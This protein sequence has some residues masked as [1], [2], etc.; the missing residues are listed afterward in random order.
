MLHVDRGVDIDSGVEQL[1]DILP[2]FGMPRA[3][4]VGMRQFIDEDQRGAACQRGIEV[5]FAEGGAT[6]LNGTPWQDVEPF[7]QGFGLCPAMRIHPAH[8]DV[9]TLITPLVGRFEHGVR[10][11][12]TSRG[13]KED[14]EFTA[15]LLGL[16]CLYTGEE[17]IGIRSLIVHRRV[18]LTVR[19]H[20]ALPEHHGTRAEGGQ[21]PVLLCTMRDAS[22]SWLAITH[23]MGRREI[24]AYRGPG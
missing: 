14:L 19:F 6:I 24:I 13:A 11:A 12:Y 22:E 10:L 4:G 21:R 18:H 9:D 16:F 1:L 5:K 7:Q 20:G 8:H 17:G 23:K 2:A 3:R 15:G